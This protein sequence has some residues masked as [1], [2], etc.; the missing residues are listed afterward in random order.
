M[1]LHK[2]MTAIK[3]STV[4]LVVLGAVLVVTPAYNEMEALD[5]EKKHSTLGNRYHSLQIRDPFIPLVRK[6]ILKVKRPA[7]KKT[8][9]KFFKTKN[10]TRCKRQKCKGHFKS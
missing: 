6:K 2:H 7:L 4:F 10:K 1:Q 9:K 8:P 5:K 3:V